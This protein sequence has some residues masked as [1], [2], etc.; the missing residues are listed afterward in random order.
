MEK[1][2]KQEI[3]ELWIVIAMLAIAMLLHILKG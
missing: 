3:L 2:T 1:A